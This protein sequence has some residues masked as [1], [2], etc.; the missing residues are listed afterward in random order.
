MKPITRFVGLDRAFWANIKLI[1]ETLGYSKRSKGKDEARALRR[2]A[3]EEVSNCLAQRGLS[4]R[5]NF[6]SEPPSETDF[7]K[8]L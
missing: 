1:S 2:Y 4:T 5:H 6:V 7:G 8:L 3:L